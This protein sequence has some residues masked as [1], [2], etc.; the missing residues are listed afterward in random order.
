V[1]LLFAKGYPPKAILLKTGNIDTATTLKLLVQAKE[2]IFEWHGK[3]TGL[4]EIALGK[5]GRN[6]KHQV[7]VMPD[8][9]TGKKTRLLPRFLSMRYLYYEK[10]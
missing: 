10:L 9:A 6:E 5:R 7:T 1:N 2:A 3:K 8:F 4:F